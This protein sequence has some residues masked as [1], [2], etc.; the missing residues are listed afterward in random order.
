MSFIIEHWDEQNYKRLLSHLKG[1]SNEKYCKF[2]S[3]LV[4]NKENILGVSQ[5]IMQGIAKEIVK[6]NWREFLAISKDT[7]YEEVMLQ[8]LVIGF[9]KTDIDEIL[10]LVTGFIPKIDNW[11]V[12]DSFC[13]GLK[14]TKKN[15]EKMFEFISRYFNSNNEFDLRFAAVMLLDFYIN[16]EY[17]ERVLNIYD[18]IHHDGY[19]VK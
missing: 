13:T 10:E 18:S 8:G 15:P 4:P 6:G 5:P 14:I 1:S 17:I 12:C 3:G 11:A 7:L 9:A 2:H 16:E 19:Y